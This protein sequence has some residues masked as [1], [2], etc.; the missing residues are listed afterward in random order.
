[1]FGIDLT[2]SNIAG[3]SGAVASFQ[4]IIES[5]KL[6]FGNNN[7][8]IDVIPGKPFT[9][10]GLQAALTL[11]G[12]PAQPGELKQITGVTPQWMSFDTQTLEISGTPPPSVVS[13]NF[14]IEAVDIYGDTAT[15]II[16]ISANPSGDLIQGPFSTLN[17]VIGSTFNYTL[18]SSLFPESGTKISAELG[19]TTSWLTF[20]SGTL[21]LSG[22]VPKGLGSQQDELEIV[23]SQGTQSQTQTLT[24]ILSQPETTG[25]IIASSITRSSLL[26]THTSASSPTT[27]PAQTSA[28]RDRSRNKLVAAAVVIPLVAI[29]GIGL[30]LYWCISAA[31]R[32]RR[33]R[34]RGDSVVRAIHISRPFFWDRFANMEPRTRM[35]EKRPL[36]HSRIPSHA[37]EIENIRPHSARL[38]EFTLL[39]E[40]E[41]PLRQSDA[42]CKPRGR[43]MSE[44]KLIRVAAPSPQ[45]GFSHQSKRYS[46]MSLACS[47]GFLPNHVS[48]VGHGVG[49]NEVEASNRLSLLSRR[50]SDLGSRRGLGHGK[51]SFNFGTTS[52]DRVANSWRNAHSDSTHSSDYVTTT[53]M[54]PSNEN[55][56]NTLSSTLNRFPPPASYTPRGSRTLHGNID[57]HSKRSSRHLPNTI[58]LV[59]D[60]GSDRRLS[61]FK[62]RSRF[63]APL[64]SAGPSSRKSSQYSTAKNP[65]GMHLDSYIAEQAD[66]KSCH[67][68]ARAESQCSFAPPNSIRPQSSGREKKSP[69]FF[70]R[71]WAQTALRV[72]PST[73]SLASSRHFESANESEASS[74]HGGTDLIVE[75]GDD[76]T[77]PH[78][79][80]TELP[81]PLALHRVS[82]SER[83]K[84]AM[85]GEGITLG[86]GRQRPVS[87]DNN[88]G[89]IRGRPVSKSMRGDLAFV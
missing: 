70:P 63:P 48:C 29:L 76:D 22:N 30:L 59:D 10:S 52:F 7:F 41:V 56:C 81:N 77:W 54:N 31:K 27:Q 50:R 89:M 14:S 15:T 42:V 71:K 11:D 73:S 24:I 47:S 69:S 79:E 49:M 20:D 33:G 40:D 87:I 75:E 32:R 12:T 45:R 53:D 35:S 28:D 25:D 2:A 64:F 19:N 43:R 80:R 1:M 66:K 16:Y 37:P 62:Q 88:S 58:R 78:G 67:D 13:Q 18:N 21:T 51:E 5:H 86:E 6:T 17:A 9:Y 65:L 85:E 61:Y 38:P 74:E 46:R 84:S 39:N 44:K 55:R 34:I 8:T 60:S 57:G 72:K 26:A 3:F 23:A 4:I 82:M 83:M 36:R 68:I